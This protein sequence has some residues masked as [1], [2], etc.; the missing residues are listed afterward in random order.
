MA[1]YFI[2]ANQAEN[3]SKLKKCFN[4]RTFDHSAIDCNGE[5]RCVER[6]GKHTVENCNESK[7]QANCADCG[8]HT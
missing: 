8:A 1:V 5:L 2:A 3:H 4:C 6:A 7:K